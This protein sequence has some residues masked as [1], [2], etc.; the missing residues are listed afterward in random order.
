MNVQ[1]IDCGNCDKDG[2]QQRDDVADAHDTKLLGLSP[3]RFV[4]LHCG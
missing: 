1:G 4:G 3:P 2:H